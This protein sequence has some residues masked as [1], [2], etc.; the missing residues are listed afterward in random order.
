MPGAKL[1]YCKVLF[2]CT[3][4]DSFIQ[5]ITDTG[6]MYEALTGKNKQSVA[7]CERLTSK[8]V[9]SFIKLYAEVKILSFIHNW[10]K[11][12]DGHGISEETRAQYCKDMMAWLLIWIRIMTTQPLM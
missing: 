2:P 7:G 8:G 11:A 4:R 9:I 12:V 6:L 5:S 3:D 1:R 10:R